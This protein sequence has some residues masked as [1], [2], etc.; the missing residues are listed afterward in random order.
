MFVPGDVN[1]IK[2][3][4]SVAA[5]LACSALISACYQ[6]V[7]GHEGHDEGEG[8]KQGDQDQHQDGHKGHHHGKK[9][10]QQGK[11]GQQDGHQGHDHDKDQQGR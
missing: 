5:A 7:L 3:L 6:P 8:K 4:F 9:D 10:Q 2:N 11:K 1:M